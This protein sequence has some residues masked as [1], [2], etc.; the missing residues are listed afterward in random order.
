[1]LQQVAQQ[2]GPPTGPGGPPPGFSTTKAFFELVQ[3][4]GYFLAIGALAALV[5]IATS[6]LVSLP[7]PK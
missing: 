6:V 1:V 2:V 5:L 3:F 7:S 4:V